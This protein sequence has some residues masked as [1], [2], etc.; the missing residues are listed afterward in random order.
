MLPGWFKRAVPFYDE[1]RVMAL[2][3]SRSAVECGPWSGVRA[4][5]AT[6]RLRAVTGGMRER[7]RR[8]TR[9]DPD[10][11]CWDTPLG[12]LWTPPGADTGYVGLLSAE[13][14]VDVYGP[15]GWGVRPGDTVVDCGANIG[16]FVRH[17]L[18]RRAHRVVA[19]EPGTLNA[20]CLGRNL[21]DAIAAGQVIVAVRAVWDRDEELFLEI[22]AEANPGSNR[23]AEGGGAGRGTCVQATTLDRLVAETGLD[24]V[25]FIKMDVEGAERRALAGAVETLRRFRPRLAI[26]VE[27]TPDPAENARQVGAF[28]RAL[29]YRIRPG[30]CRVNPRRVVYP[31]VLYARGR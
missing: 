29:G 23:I 28:L 22:V 18:A 7:C 12:T 30:F 5:R 2:S 16:V 11:A 21:G 4:Y 24:R 10:F 14:A 26:A 15:R 17:A 27:H 9:I 13:V 25:D 3:A 20:A 31:E 1:A 19:V 8:S 6:R